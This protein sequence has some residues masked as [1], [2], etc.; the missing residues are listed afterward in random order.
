MRVLLYEE[1]KQKR[2]SAKFKKRA[3]SLLLLSDDA[4]SS[5]LFKLHEI[6]K[7]WLIARVR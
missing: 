1:R 5:S 4:D 7:L 2:F 3:P 6:N